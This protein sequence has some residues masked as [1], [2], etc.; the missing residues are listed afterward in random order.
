M[1]K[2]GPFALAFNF[3]VVVFVLAPL[4]IVCLSLIHI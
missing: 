4:A 2:N 3:L 1:Q